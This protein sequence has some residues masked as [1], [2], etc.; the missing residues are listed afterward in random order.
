V[1]N[2]GGVV[3]ELPYDALVIG[4]GA[5]PARPPIAGLTGPDAV[6]PD[7]GVHLLHS[8]GDTFAVAESI[9][10]RQPTTAVVIGAGYI[11]LEM[12]ESLTTLGIQVTQIEA[13]PEVL[14]TVDPHLGRLVHTELETHGVLVHT[15]HRRR[16][17]VDRA[18]STS[19]PTA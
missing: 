11:G 9:K 3:S 10:N 14:P 4:T 12:A 16:A 19:R 5:V 13:L 8:M 2:P 7:D 18:A 17:G 1:Q 6:G 15:L